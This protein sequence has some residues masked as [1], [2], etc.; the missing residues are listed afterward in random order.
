MLR[1]TFCLSVVA[2]GFA[3]FAS[4]ATDWARE[5][6]ATYATMVF[7]RSLKAEF[8]LKG[9]TQDFAD[10]FN[11]L[12]GT[13]G[14][15]VR[16]RG[17]TLFFI[18]DNPKGHVNGVHRWLERNSDIIWPRPAGD[19]CFYTPNPGFDLRC[20]QSDYRDVP[21][22]TSRHLSNN[23]YSPETWRWFARNAATSIVDVRYLMRKKPE[24]EDAA[25]KYAF[26]GA[27][28]DTFG[29]GHDMEHF[30]FPR[31]EFFKDHPEYWMEIDGKRWEGPWSNFCETNPGFVEAFSKSVERKIADLPE[32]VKTISILMEDQALTCTCRECQKPI[33]LQDGSTVGPDDP[34]FR[35]TRFF[36]FFNQVARHVAAIRPDLRIM[37][38]AYLH[39]SVPPK[40]KIAPN[41]ILKFC[42]F[43]RDMHQSVVEGSAN[44]KWRER[45]D[46]WLENTPNLYWREYYFCSNQHFPRPICDTAATDLRYIASRCV[47]KVF[48]EMPAWGGDVEKVNTAYSL[49]RPFS[50]FFTMNGIEG[51]TMGKLFWD[52]YQDPAALRADFLR[53]TFGPSAKAL[54]EFYRLLRAGWDSDTRFVTYCDDPFLMTLRYVVDKGSADKCMALLAE[55]EKTAD[56]PDRRKWTRR[57][58]KVFEAWLSEAKGRGTG[59]FEVPFNVDG[60]GKW[61]KF[62]TLIP[63]RGRRGKDDSGSFFRICSDGKAFKIEV[64]VCKQDVPVTDCQPDKDGFLCGDKAE[65]FFG[66]TDGPSYQ[67]VFDS[68][69]RTFEA[70]GPDASWAGNWKVSAERTADGWR[71]IAEIPFASIGFAPNVN[72]RIRF[73]PVLSMKTKY[74]EGVRNFSWKAAMPHKVSDWGELNV[75]FAP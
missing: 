15:A 2:T 38:F 57:M 58:R 22:F 14:Y 59:A 27:F 8:V 42:P 48:T 33:R 74:A 71:A 7:G 55:A 35:S 75:A 19:L 52:P 53:R 31:T 40:V 45:T 37:Q 41:V 69:G 17:E 60:K 23:V 68:A 39:L 26:L 25:R 9:D 61:A 56:T 34:A 6:L 4:P 3:S 21:V 66:T 67:F 13:D 73:L 64:M 72:P 30:W 36:I 54:A 44:R 50:D 28:D 24:L 18:A 65:L 1:V 51:W 5:E 11:A 70:K 49:N 47:R 16:L 12:K 20:S 32:G 10:D 43:P 63:V 46:A 29:E 62:P